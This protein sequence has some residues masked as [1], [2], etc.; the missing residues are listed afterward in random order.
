MVL[1]PGQMLV[2]G[3]ML[4]IGLAGC[5]KSDSAVAPAEPVKR[6]VSDEQLRTQVDEVIR[7]TQARHM[8]AEVHNAWQIVHGILAY[9]RDLQIK[10]GD[11]LVSALDFLLA[12]GEIRG[13]SFRRGDHGLV[14]VMEPGTKQGQGH[15]DQWLGYLSQCGLAPTQTLVIK[16][17]TFTLQ[18]LLTEAQW[19]IFPGMESS[20]T[21][22]A[23]ST[24][25]PP[26]AVWQAKDGTEWSVERIAEMEAGQDLAESPCGGTHRLYG[27]AMALNHHLNQGGELT[28]GWKI[29][30]EKVKDSIAK[31][32]QFQQPDGSFS[33]GFFNRPGS[34]PDI[35][36]VLHATGHTFELLTMGMSD[37]EIRQ[38][39][40][41]RAALALCE[42][43]EETREMEV[44]CG[45]LYH[46]AHG[47][48]LYRDRIFGAAPIVEHTD[49]HKSE[50]Q[51]TTTQSSR[52]PL[53][54]KSSKTDA[55]GRSLAHSN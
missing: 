39:A 22:M 23:L 1:R 6:E 38:P 9:G 12:G 47:L 10:A 48:I 35:A 55:A 33:T 42:M 17:E 5:A 53:P 37:E 15:H 52:A 45:A 29:A 46:A 44:E 36:T 41:R 28:G 32:K 3:L 19:D 43:L 24:Y 21:L 2:L 50:T 30:D 40:M 20:W 7:F 51:K 8:S 31:A 11:K 14:S 54:A 4:S 26:G 18:D 16:G 34:S 27:L 25:L 49:E 13:W